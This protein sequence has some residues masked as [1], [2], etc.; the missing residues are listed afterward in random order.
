MDLL[1]GTGAALCPFGPG[2]SQGSAL[3]ELQIGRK[4]DPCGP[5]NA[6]VVGR[7]KSSSEDC[8]QM[9]SGRHWL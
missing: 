4:V 2:L 8:R 1:K 6:S 9:C 3:R 7:R 5:I